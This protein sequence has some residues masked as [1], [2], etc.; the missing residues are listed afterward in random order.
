MFSYSEGL[1]SIGLLPD[2]KV[3][4]ADELDQLV[5]QWMTTVRPPSAARVSIE[6]PSNTTN[7]TRRRKGMSKTHGPRPLKGGQCWPLIAGLCGRSPQRHAINRDSINS[8]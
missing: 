6:P 8:T 4:Y 1:F 3:L 5:E 2:Y 7:E